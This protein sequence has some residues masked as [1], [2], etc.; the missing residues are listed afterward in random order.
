V[1]LTKWWMLLLMNILMIMSGID[2]QTKKFTEPPEQI[3]KEIAALKA[4]KAPASLVPRPPRTDCAQSVWVEWRPIRVAGRPRLLGW[5]DPTSA[6]QE[7]CGEQ[8][9]G[10]A[11]RLAFSLYCM[12]M[13]PVEGHMTIRRRIHIRAMW[14]VSRGRWCEGQSGSGWLITRGAIDIQLD[15]NYCVFAEGF[16]PNE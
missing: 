14:R 16:W 7:M 5:V 15:R 12:S 1:R 4:D 11:T 13:T 2:P 8:S 9:W 6:C 3:K 10:N